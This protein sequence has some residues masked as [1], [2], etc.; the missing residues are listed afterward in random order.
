MSI[1]WT[2]RKPQSLAQPV[3]KVLDYCY[4]CHHPKGAHVVTSYVAK[5]ITV[6]SVCQVDGCPCTKYRYY[7]TGIKLPRGMKI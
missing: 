4:V 5:A 7:A 6:H 2:K 3:N 1:D